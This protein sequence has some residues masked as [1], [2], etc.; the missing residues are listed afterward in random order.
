MFRI[1]S[2]VRRF[3]NFVQVP[4]LLVCASALS[5]QPATHATGGIY[6]VA[7]N[8]VYVRS[9]GSLNH[10]TICKL[11]AGDRVTVVS[12]QGKWYEILPPEGT[13]SLISGDFV[14]TAGDKSG[15]INGNNVRVR[16]GSHLNTQKYTVQRLLSKGAEVTI[17][18]RNA[19]GFL[20]IAPPEGATLWISAEF[21]APISSGAI[22][23]RKVEAPEGRLSDE[24]EFVAS[25][26][27][28][29]AT[30]PVEPPRPVSKTR[31]P[32]SGYGPMLAALPSTREREAL[33]L[34]DDEVG[35]ELTKPLLDRQVEPFIRRYQALVDQDNDP[36]AQRYAQ[37]RIDQLTTMTEIAGT[38]RKVRTLSEQTD[39][40]RHE[41]LAERTS[42]RQAEIPKPSGIDAR[43]ELR[44]SALYP[45]GK[46]PRRYRLVDTSA[47]TERTIGYVD[48]PADT[49]INVSAL[50]GRYVGVRASQ[51]RLLA[52]GVNP[53]PIFLARELVLLD[54]DVE[55]TGKTSQ[56]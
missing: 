18:G 28:T 50:L 35:L 8:D 44:V 4:V 12:Q 45:E 53:I 23:Q 11:N 40:R 24:A 31:N 15:V 19:D 38:V 20:R 32:R 33:A 34:I 47:P 39:A 48:I 14:D 54:S 22:A 5:A 13:Y 46:L 1:V 36:F 16:A 26:S 42:R 17:L 10:Y 56:D 37:T 43:G 29:A 51:K 27:D 21:I 49:E 3:R 9:G 55:E 7:A 52:G 30:D 25:G 2:S 6:E 41:F